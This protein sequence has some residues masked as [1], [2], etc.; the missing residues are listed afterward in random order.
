MKILGVDVATEPT[1][2][3]KPIVLIAI[4]A[5]CFVFLD[6]NS[7]ALYNPLTHGQYYR[8]FTANFIH[9][10]FNHL[11]LNC[12]GVMLV[13]LFFADHFNWPRYA[14]VLFICCIGSSMAGF[15]LLA[16]DTIVGLSGAL[17]GVFVYGAMR[18]IIEKTNIET[19]WLIVIGTF[20]KVI[21]EN[22]SGLS[23]GSA[24]L[25]NARVAVEVHLSGSICGLLLGFSSIYWQKTQK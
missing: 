22:T 13:W 7:F 11:I 17:H 3:L 23:L 14:G 24:E 9:T 4:L 16:N 15:M 6:K 19:G 5:I 8:L 12:F 20:G 21:L 25:I 1:N 18:D 2:I 10:N